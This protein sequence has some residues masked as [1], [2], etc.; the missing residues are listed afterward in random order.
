MTQAYKSA[1]KPSAFVHADLSVGPETKCVILL[2]KHLKCNEEST[3]M[4]DVF[5]KKKY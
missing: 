3:Y 4:D 2:I 1:M 5:F